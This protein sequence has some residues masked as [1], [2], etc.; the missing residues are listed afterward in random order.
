MNS[1]P[2]R[3][4]VV[5]GYGCCPVRMPPSRPRS[6]DTVPPTAS[7]PGS[8]ARTAAVSAVHR[9]LRRAGWGWLAVGCHAVPGEGGM[10]VVP[11]RVVASRHTPNTGPP[12][13]AALPAAARLGLGAAG[14]PCVRPGY[15]GPS[16][17][18][19]RGV[20]SGLG[21]PAR[22]RVP[23]R[24]V[25]GLPGATGRCSPPPT[26]A[27]SARGGRRAAASSRRPWQPWWPARTAGIDDDPAFTTPWGF[28]PGR[29]TVP[30]LLL[31]NSADRVVPSSH[32][33]WLGHRCLT[34][35]LRLRLPEGRGATSS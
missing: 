21:A 31:H 1:S 23:V 25:C 32:N 27:R 11:C 8:R 2:Q 22:W 34:T 20:A 7:P 33:Q 35:R 26:V 6:P 24:P 5:C 30:A 18:P 16:P 19:G 12:S 13:W 15:G 4:G 3:P 29:I 14:S 28:G 9:R 10:V 17:S